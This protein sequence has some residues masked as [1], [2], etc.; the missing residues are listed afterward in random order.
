MGLV[1]LGSAGSQGSDAGSVIVNLAAGA[2]AST[3]GTGSY[4]VL[5]QSV[6]GGGGSAVLAQS[7]GGGGGSAGVA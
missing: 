5:A 1:A 4:A 3:S 6:G 2:Y 7:V